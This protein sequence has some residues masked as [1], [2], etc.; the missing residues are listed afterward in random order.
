MPSDPV[1]PAKQPKVPEKPPEIV[2][3]ERQ[4][5]TPPPAGLDVAALFNTLLT[6]FTGAQAPAE[7]AP[8]A[9]P[10]AFR[11]AY[12]PPQVSEEG[13]PVAAAGFDIKSL[14]IPAGLGLALFMA[15]KFL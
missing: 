2:A 15:R 10:R 7:V 5:A 3:A 4:P 6:T 13:E 11:P 1:T 8:A 9:Q 14:M 12:A